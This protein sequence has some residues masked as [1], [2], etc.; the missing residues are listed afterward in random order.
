MLSPRPFNASRA[1]PVALLFIIALLIY[2]ADALAQVTTASVTLAVNTSQAQATAIPNDFSGLSFEMGSVTYD[3]VNGGWYLSGSNGAMIALAKTLGVKSVRVGGNSAETGNI[4]TSADEDTVLDFCH[5]IGAN[6]IW[7]LEVDGTL[8]DPSN[9][10]SDPYGK[11][12]VAQGMQNYVNS[13]AY[14]TNSNSLVFQ[15]G[16]E[17]DLTSEPGGSGNKTAATYDS[18]FSNYIANTN[19]LYSGSRWAGPDTAAG[20]TFYSPTFCPAEGPSGQV[21]FVCQHLYPFGS[22]LTA[23]SI[24]SQVATMLSSSVDGGYKSFMGQW[25]PYATAA[26]L[27]PRYEECNSYFHNGS[28]GSSNAYASALWGLDW[29]YYHAQAGLAGINFHTGENSNNPA[30]N[31][32]TPT[33]LTTAYTVHPLAYAMLAFNIGGHGRIVP[34]TIGNPT[35]VNIVAY[36]VLQGDGS[37][38]ITAVNRTYG[39]PAYN[40]S[41]SISTSGT[42]YN[43]A[44]VMFLTGSNNDPTATTGAMLGGSA[45]SG[46]GAWT[47]TYMGMAAPVSSTFALT[48]PPAQAAV[49]RLFAANGP[50]APVSLT[51]TAGNTAA[52][53]NWNVSTSATGYVIERASVTGGP[54]TTVA[55]GVANNSYVDT[56]VANGSTYY[57]VVAAMNSNG[58]GPQSA[59]A[60]ATLPQE[61]PVPPGGIA[62]TPGDSVVSLS[63]NAVAG[64]TNYIV[65]SSTNSSG[66]YTFAASTP[67]TNSLVGGLSDGVIYYFTVSAVGAYGQG[68][69]SGAVAETPFV[70]PGNGWINTVTSST[71]S[72]NVNSNWSNSAAYPNSAQSVALVNSAITASQ[73]INLNQVITIGELQMGASSGGGS[74]TLAGNGGTL[75]FQNAPAPGSVLQLASSK[76]DTISAPI[77]LTGNLNISNASANPLT[78]SGNI[79]GTNNIAF[80]GGTVVLAGATT[81]S[82]TATAVAGAL[83]LVNSLA[84]QDAILNPGGGA[85]TFNGITAVSIGALIGTG[86]VNLANTSS[87]PVTMT[88]GNDDLNTTY[89]GALTGPGSLTVAGSGMLT[90][91]GTSNYTGTTTVATGNLTIASGTFGS[92]SGTIVVGNGAAGVSFNVTGGVAIAKTINIA[93]SGGST[94]DYAAITGSGSAA[95][96]N[97]NIGSGSNTS[98]GITINTTGAVSLGVLT[99]ARD[100]GAGAGLTVEGGIVTATSVDIQANS[101]KVANMDISGGSTTIGTSSSTNAFKVGDAGDGGFLT[102]TGGSLTYLGTDGLLLTTAAAIGS[103]SLTSGTTTLTGITLNSGS[104]TTATSTLTLQSGAMLYLGS[105]GLVAKLP[106][107]NVS[108]SFGSATLGAIA[109]FSSAAPATLTGTLTIQAADSLGVAHNI[110]YTGALSGTGGLIKTGAGQLTLNGTGSYT[111]VT[112]VS[113][114]TLLI[115]G[116]INS[117]SNVTVQAGATLGVTAGTLTSGTTTISAGGTLVDNGTVN[118]LIINQ[119]SIFSNS[120]GTVTINGNVTNNGTV[121]VTNGT[122]LSTTGTFTNYGIFDIMTG[123]QTLPA[124]FVNNGTVLNSSLV[125]VKSFAMTSSSGLAI[126]IQTYP[127]HTYQFQSETSLG[128]PAWINVSTNITTATDGNGVMTFSL[129]NLAGNSRFYRIQVGP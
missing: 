94:G 57:Y 10:A 111:G 124:R 93:P 69:A 43:D 56:G 67:G 58:L 15:V 37:L 20:G 114:G 32:V 11:P 89:A 107:P 62:G 24:P 16:N 126:A 112:N 105:V 27:A 51:A 34:V 74:F 5:A 96:T 26:G 127:N 92:S 129:T 40:A 72:W 118:G 42:T 31:A 17:P 21:A 63:W 60:N 87:A 3:S 115:T 49:I 83:Q 95:F 13:K 76:G 55:S 8:Y 68:L 29:M 81:Y 101:D 65:E 50:V 18:E 36:S 2:S 47:G 75:T 45:I 86:N 4:A 110:T 7:D 128:N 103:A 108:I 106:D 120:G 44:Q 121:T 33:N 52:T 78:L 122:T 123:A 70:N 41:L 99:N 30:Y 1:L 22:S 79:S 59:E 97:V 23:G 109:S 61:P 19:A 102:V 28:F 125:K 54:Y 6:L 88:V 71:Q 12:V 84:L 104:S 14:Q 98:G 25:V 82:G 90:L 39:S 119:G 48:V 38:I 35:S 91:T 46:Q 117:G 100:T 9:S 64:A 116:T 53:L 66:P 85:V 77:A 73:T 80:N 113:A